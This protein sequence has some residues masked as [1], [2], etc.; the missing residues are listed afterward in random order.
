MLDMVH[1]AMGQAFVS[2]APVMT[3]TMHNAVIKTLSEGS[4]QGYTGPCYQQPGQMNSAPIGSTTVTPPSAPLSQSEGGNGSTFPQSINTTLPPQFGPV[5][6][7]SPP[8]ITSV[9]GGSTSRSPVE[10]DLVTSFGMPPGSFSPSTLGQ[11]NTSA[12]Q[13]MS[14]QQNALASQLIM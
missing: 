3:N 11:N 1:Q 2:H 5:F 8:F 7:N 12:S 14:H 4:F 10:C 6:T 9:Q 13:P